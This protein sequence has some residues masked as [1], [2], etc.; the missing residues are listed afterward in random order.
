MNHVHE[1]VN[2]VHQHVKKVTGKIGV[3]FITTLPSFCAAPY[4][5]TI[6]RTV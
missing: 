3:T 1:I 6:Y 5:Y 4:I 2:N